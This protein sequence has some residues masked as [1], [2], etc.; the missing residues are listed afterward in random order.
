MQRDTVRIG[1]FEVVLPSMTKARLRGIYA[2]VV[3]AGEVAPGD[4]IEVR[5]KS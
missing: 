5:R 3:E 2:K 1:V 4:P